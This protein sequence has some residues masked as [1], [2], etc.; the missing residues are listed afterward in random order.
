[1]SPT[2]PPSWRRRATISR[3]SS[4]RPT[5]SG[6]RAGSWNT[7]PAVEGPSGGRDKGGVAAGGWVGPGRI[8]F[9]STSSACAIRGKLAEKKVFLSS[10]AKAIENVELSKVLKN[11]EVVS[12]KTAFD[13][14][15]AV[16]A[17]L[18]R[19]QRVKGGSCRGEMSGAPSSS[20]PNH[21]N[22]TDFRSGHARAYL[23]RLF[24][25]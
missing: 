8:A 15:D 22:L 18:N 9:T 13:D 4:S 5:K 16:R 6:K 23:Q 21:E 24:P 25:C 12:Y 14:P 7:R 11:G 17:I 3:T 20:R 2:Q 19:V 1:M 10:R